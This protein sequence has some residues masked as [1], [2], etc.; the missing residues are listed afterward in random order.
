MAAFYIILI[1]LLA[2]YLRVLIT[3]LWNPGFI[4]RGPQWQ[5]LQADA[6][7]SVKRKDGS[8]RR[9]RSGSNTVQEKR[10]RSLGNLEAG[11][12]NVAKNNAYSFDAS[13]LESFYLKDVFVCQPDGKPAW[14]SVCC[15]FKTDRAHHCREVGRCVRKMDHFCP[16][17]VARQFG[18]NLRSPSPFSMSSKLT[19]EQG[20]WRNQR[21]FFQVL[22]SGC[23]LWTTL[24]DL[25]PNCDGYICSRTPKRGTY[26]L[27]QCWVRAAAPLNLVFDATSAF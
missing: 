26:G 23:L 3:I 11:I 13:G 21:D 25:K 15:Q 10:D 22:Y 20:W 16:W 19:Q 18:T 1:P 12:E 2:A 8:G 6:K 9:R 24:H 17:Y 14:C 7:N 4:P 27:C 5:N